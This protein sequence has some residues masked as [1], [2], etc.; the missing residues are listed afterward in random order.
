[1]LRVGVVF[2]LHAMVMPG[3]DSDRCLAVPRLYV[4]W[5]GRGGSRP[6]WGDTP[7]PHHADDPHLPPRRHE[8]QRSSTAWFCASVPTLHRVVA[9]RVVRLGL[10]RGFAKCLSGML[11]VPSPRDRDRRSCRPS[12]PSRRRCCGP[13]SRC[14]RC[15]PCAADCAAWARCLG[16][17]ARLAGAGCGWAAPA[18]LRA[19]GR[20]ISQPGRPRRVGELSKTHRRS[21]FGRR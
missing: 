5:A 18:G 8:V 6:G 2:A 21:W 12:V 13:S 10:L 7:K 20:S 4:A 3:L 11:L 14:M 17:G 15:C 19:G 16:W 1:L 9:G